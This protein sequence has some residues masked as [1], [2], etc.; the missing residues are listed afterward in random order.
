MATHIRCRNS[1]CATRFFDIKLT[2]CPDCGTVRHGYSSHLYTAALDGHLWK[3]AESADLVNKKYDHIRKGGQ[4]P[5]TPRQRA[6]AK[7]IVADLM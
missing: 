3:Q 1:E 7:R 6:E 5:P 4:I 2:A